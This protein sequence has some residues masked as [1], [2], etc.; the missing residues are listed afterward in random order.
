MIRILTICLFLSGGLSLQGQNLVDE[1]GRKSGHWK[2]E[3]PNGRTHYEAFF[4]EG[5]PVGEMLRYYEKGGIKARMLFEEKGKRSYASLFY[6]SGKPSAEGWYVD[7]VKDS[8]WTY[9]SNFDG[10]VRIREPYLEG[11]LNGVSQNYYPDGVISEEVEW[12]E[13]VKD[14]AWTQYYKNGNPRLS[15]HYKDGLLQGSYEVYFSDNTIEIRGIYLD[16]LSNGTWRFYDESGKEV[17]VLEYVNGIPADIEKYELWIQDSLKNYE[18][19]SEP[20]TNVQF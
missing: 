18:V 6:T 7:Q 5:S 20:E 1:E 15:G 2:V 16:N 9:Y 11:K 10:S 8:V 12:K 14:G 3:Y 19:I 17:Y 4:V 13:N